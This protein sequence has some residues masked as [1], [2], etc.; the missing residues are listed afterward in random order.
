MS[1]LADHGL[2]GHCD[3]TPNGRDGHAGGRSGRRPVDPGAAGRLRAVSTAGRAPPEEL[4]PLDEPF[5]ADSLSRLRRA[6]ARHAAA[7]GLSADRVDDAVIAVHELAANAVYH[8]AGHGRVRQ[9]SDQQLLHS[10]VS[11]PGPAPPSSAFAE[12]YPWT[13]NY[14]HG[15]WLV[16]QTAD[17]VVVNHDQSGTDV[18]ISFAIGLS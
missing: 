14:G 9:W 10:H 4:P 15:L 17:R 8:G 7:A 18:T 5:D 16:S 1:R 11:D 13:A 12:H 2:A 3:G 6:V